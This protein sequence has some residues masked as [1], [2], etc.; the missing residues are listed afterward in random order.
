MQIDPV[1]DPH[2][3]LRVLFEAHHE[4][5]LA[6]ARRRTRE[7]LD[8]EDV[9]AETFVVV[10][11]R[12]DRLPANEAERLPWLYGIARRVVANQ[13]R[14]AARR[15]RLRGRME[16]ATASQSLQAPSPLPGVLDA[17]S[18]L[19]END[20][21][22]L[23]LVAWEGLTHAEVGVVLGISPNAAAI[24]LH[25]ARAHLEREMRAPSGDVKGPRRIRTLLGWK[26]SASSA[27]EREE[28]R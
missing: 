3:V 17:M 6:Y 2:H 15:G 24:R 9:V 21:E 19:R 26:G 28:A 4:P 10:W 22:V 23:R 18:R 14:S 5:L 12:L 1:G 11:R 27:Q 7:L 16:V 20:R 8:A 25:R 13:H